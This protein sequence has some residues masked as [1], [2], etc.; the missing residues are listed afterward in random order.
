MITEEAFFLHDE[1]GILG[2][3]RL[4]RAVACGE[5]GRHRASL[6]AEPAQ[7]DVEDRAVHPLAHDVA[8]DRAG[9]AYKRASHDQRTVSQGETDTRC[10]PAGIG[11]QH[12][13]DDRHVGAADRENEKQPEG[14]TD[15]D[16]ESEGDG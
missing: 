7:D 14:E 10:R 5:A 16:D 3:A 4:D 1:S 11:I 12:R 2:R 13:Y 9:G 6:G 15:E 8:E